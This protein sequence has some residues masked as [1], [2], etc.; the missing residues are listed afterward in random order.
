MYLLAGFLIVANN[1]Y[2]V[3]HLKQVSE[4]MAYKHFKEIKINLH[5]HF[6]IPLEGG[7]TWENYAGVTEKEK[8]YF[9]LL[10]L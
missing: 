3:S 8:S 2:F 5:E 10:V 7:K 1:F 4:Q 6:E 9:P